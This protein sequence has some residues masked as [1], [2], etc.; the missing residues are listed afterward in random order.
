MS[1]DPASIELTPLQ[2]ERLAAIAERTGKDYVTIVDELLS[3]AVL[4]EAERNGPRRNASQ[5]RSAYDAFAAVGAIG[6]FDGP[7]DLSTNPKYMEGFGLNAS[8][9]NSD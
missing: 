4:P 2:K 8:R 3:S 6:C 9:R 5:P 7:P 1:I